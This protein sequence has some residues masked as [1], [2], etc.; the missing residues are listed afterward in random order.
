ML[1]VGADVCRNPEIAGHR[2]WLETNGLGGFSSSTITGLNTRR[3]HGLLC[4]AIQPPSQRYMLL[5]KL[6]ETLI[7][8]GIRYDLGVNQYPGSV[9]PT[10]FEF[11]NS[12][13][14]DP[15]PTFAWGV[16][17]VELT[18]SIFLVHESN[19]VVVEYF[20][21]AQGPAAK[22]D[23]KMEVRPLLACRGYHELS[24]ANNFWRAEYE[25]AEGR[26]VLT[27]YERFPSLHIAHDAVEVERSGYWYYNFEYAEE[28]R[29]GLD[30]REDLFQ[31]MVLHFD[32]N[33]RPRAA[34]IASLEQRDIASVPELRNAE[35][36]RRKTT[37]GKLALA[38]D[39]FVV[40]RG[41]RHSII[42]GYPWFAD[43]GRDT[44]VSLP[45]LTLST[46]RS[47]IA[48]EILEEFSNW[49]SE[50]M[51]PNYFPDHGEPPEY[52][53]VDS[54]LWYF[55]AVR[56]Y[57]DLTGDYRW[58]FER[59]F[60][61]LEE[62]IQAYVRG[63]RYGIRLDTDGLLHSGERPAGGTGVALTWMDARVNGIPVTPRTGK[64]VEIQ[65]LWYNALRIM[66]AF[67]ARQENGRKDFYSALADSTRDTFQARFWNGSLN[68]LFDVVDVEG[69][70]QGLTADASIRPN[71]V[72]AVSL[73]HKLLDPAAARDLLEVVERELLTPFGLRTL[74]P[75]DPQY[76]GRYEGD[77]VSRDSA[78]HQ[79]TVW[80]WL[81]G[82]FV[83]AY[84]DAHGR[85]AA[86]RQKCLQW[87]SPLREYR[88]SDGMNQLPEV[89]DGDPPHRAGGC[90][91]QAWSLAL[92]VQ[93]FQ[94]V[95]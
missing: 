11:Q 1:Y 81:M 18:K 9:H 34:V 45:G 85:D 80:P 70:D 63:T 16:E 39:Q 75:R 38:A 22:R 92:I 93:S 33:A 58:L 23:V 32:L 35:V 17:D 86:A 79:G 41:D 54:A 26:V 78:Y 31:P 84:F 36:V 88:T 67:S 7:L 87:L 83:L 29:R 71:Q 13:R 69:A 95:Y 76:R 53:S 44:M 72:F 50:G 48:R 30:F 82:P 49:I 64:P 24:H 27:P 37:G 47:A 61:G 25:V 46:A 10:G 21:R 56:A 91:A 2:E 43:W 66:E 68:C 60:A 15:F 12:F 5:S 51:L 90:P 74:S 77:A 89:F 59:I 73:T 28:R 14:I 4:A 42:A 6:E 57:V 52:N 94:T 20:L 3:Y 8:D 55:E 40:K 19:T 65:A 62:I